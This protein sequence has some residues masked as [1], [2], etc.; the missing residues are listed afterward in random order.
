MKGST[1]YC[2]AS[3]FA[4]RTR[5]RVDA[6]PKNIITRVQVQREPFHVPMPLDVTELR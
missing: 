1:N 4:T 2:T 6:T 3:K 5:I